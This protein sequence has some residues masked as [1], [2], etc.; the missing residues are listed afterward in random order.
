MLPK[1]ASQIIL[2]VVVIL[3]GST[4]VFSLST[5]FLVYKFNAELGNPSHHSGFCYVTKTPKLPRSISWV[6]GR[7]YDTLL[8]FENN[9][10]LGRAETSYEPAINEGKGRYYIYENKFIYFST[11]DN[12]NPQDN[13]RSYAARFIGP[14]AS[15]R[16]VLGLFLIF[17]LSVFV[18]NRYR[19]FARRNDIG[20]EFG[21]HLP[22][23]ATSTLSVSRS[24][25]IKTITIPVAIALSVLV[26]AE[27]LARLYY[28]RG[29][30]DLNQPTIIPDRVL[31]HR[32]A[33]NMTVFDDFR[34]PGHIFKSNAQSWMEEE[35][36]T[37]RPAENTFRIF[38][39]GDS[40]TQG[41]V[42][43][44]EKMADLVEQKLNLRYQDSETR[45]EV[46]NT[47]TSSYSTLQYYLI[48]KK[49]LGHYSPNLVV[50]NVDM[51]DVA[52]DCVYRQ[53]AI[54]NDELLPAAIRP[55]DD[56]PRNIVMTPYGAMPKPP[57]GLRVEVFLNEHSRAYDRIRNI[58]PE[59]KDWFGPWIKGGAPTLISEMNSNLPCNWLTMESWSD[60]L[61]KNV[62]YSMFVLASTIKL[63]KK[64]NIPVIVTGV[65][66]FP[67]YFGISRH[68]A[69][70][71]VEEPNHPIGA[72]STKPHNE[73]KRTTER[74]GG[75]FFNSFDA[76]KLYMIN[77]KQTD[78]YWPNDPTH[79]NVAGNK[80]WADAQIHFLLK[81]GVL[82]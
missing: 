70:W 65:P 31:H 19:K 42:G 61:K 29:A 46:I 22:N 69:F 33:P 55:F 44:G 16:V 24:Y 35:V 52:N 54:M 9:I 80:I 43:Y 7:D 15:F 21:T 2:M 60:A 45:F 73:L 20:A 78:Y 58:A 30:V 48:S 77:A 74:A 66:H 14:K 36:V 50:I 71:N 10:R 79:F 1:Q 56:T 76:L 64:R 51:T 27:G 6:F 75:L 23:N 72:W 62:E 37:P 3:L 18:L 68:E 40:N 67:Q 82:P 81:S 13:E 39:L 59:I 5:W 28:F 47:G 17:S 11:S 32:W 26:S 12:S 4:F 34:K 25:L 8:L 53:Q 38:Y 57:F 49:I 41:V 63:L